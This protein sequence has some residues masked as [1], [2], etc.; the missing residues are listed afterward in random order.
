M[1]VNILPEMANDDEFKSISL[2][3]G[4][5]GKAI[6]EALMERKKEIG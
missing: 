2:I 4:H 3:A 5:V 6:E 1:V